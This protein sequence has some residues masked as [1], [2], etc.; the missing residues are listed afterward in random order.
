MSEQIR[1]ELMEMVNKEVVGRLPN[2][3]T[4]SRTGFVTR[5]DPDTRVIRVDHVDCPE[6]W[7]EIPL[8]SVLP[9]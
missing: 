1:K 9:K 2:V 5:F 7:L 3:V 8:D 4:R 6:F